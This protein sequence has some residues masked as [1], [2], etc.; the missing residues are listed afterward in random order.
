[1]ERAA[2]GPPAPSRGCGR[3]RPTAALSHEPT[4]AHCNRLACSHRSDGCGSLAGPRAFHRWLPG[5][6]RFLGL[7]PFPV[8]H[9]GAVG[10]Q[11]ATT[12]HSASISVVTTSRRRMTEGWHGDDYI[13]VFGH[14]E[15]FAISKACDLG[16]TLPG[17][18]VLGLRSWQ[19]FIVQD[20]AGATFTIP[21]VPLDARYLAELNFPEPSDLE[22]DARFVGNQVA[23]QAAGFRRKPGGRRQ[24]DVGHASAARGSGAVVERPVQVCQGRAGLTARLPQIGHNRSLETTVPFGPHQPKFAARREP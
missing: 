8:C 1:M 20:Q 4:F 23:S 2:R 6:R 24:R 11:A 22:P 7:R 3:M 17:F 19:D 13:I 21:S 16:S 9:G 15:A 12:R 18:S 14:E 10:P 5:P